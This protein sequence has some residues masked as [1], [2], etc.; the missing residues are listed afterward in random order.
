MNAPKRAQYRTQIQRFKKHLLQLP[1]WS[2]KDLLPHGA[3]HRMIE[4]ASSVRDSIYTPLVTLGLFLRQVLSQD[5]SCQN[6]VASFSAERLQ[7]GLKPISVNTGPYCKARSRLTLG[8][9]QELVRGAGAAGDHHAQ[10]N[11]L[12]LGRWN[13]K[14]VDGTT[15]LLQ[16]TS[17]NQEAYPQPEAQKPGLGFPIIR[18]VAI[19]SLS[20][21]MVLDYALSPYQGKQTGEASL[22]AR[23]LEGLQRWDLVI[24]DRYYS[25]YAFLAIFSARGIGALMPQ[26]AQRKPD[27]RT[28]KRL[29]ARDHIVL[30]SK[31]KVKPVWMTD[32]EFASLPDELEV[33]EFRFNK[34][35]YVTT[36]MDNKI[37]SKTELGKFYENRWHVEL[38]LRSLKTHMGMEMLRCLTPVMVE[39]EIAVNLLAYNLIRAQ[40]AKAAQ[41]HNKIP[42]QLSFKASVQL[43]LSAVAQ[44]AFIPIYEL[45]GLVAGL[46]LGIASTPVGIL[47]KD[48]QPRAKKRRPKAY[49]LLVKPRAEVKKTLKRRQAKY[50]E[51]QLAA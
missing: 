33:R 46:L 29:G 23:L 6:I 20:V 22:F 17:A 5:G 11:D 2:F 4:Q 31:P 44:W 14:L 3:L 49:P 42:R 16:D 50:Q 45:R 47:K 8:P 18:M 36:L 10:S 13:V 51:D 32:Q 9:M 38:N 41:E 30:W 21:G 39:K 34:V 12:W 35:V 25:T 1:E 37:Y 7:A 24:A 40:M 15:L 43:F 26:H 19:F 28:G 27:F 48:P